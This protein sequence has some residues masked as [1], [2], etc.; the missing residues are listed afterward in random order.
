[1]NKQPSPLEKDEQRTLIDWLEIK[2]WSFS[3]LPLSTYTT[4]W[5]QKMHNKAQGVRAGVPDLMVIVPELSGN[6][7]LVFIEMKRTG[8]TASSLSQFQKKWIKDLNGT[9]GVRAFWCSGALEAIKKLEE[10]SRC[11]I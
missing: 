2:Q 4:S 10:V 1:M 3:A 5:K 9:I 11:K 7:R 8:S 6:K